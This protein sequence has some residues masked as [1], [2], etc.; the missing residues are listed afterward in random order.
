MPPND[1]PNRREAIGAIATTTLA[2][3]LPAAGSPQE[4]RTGDMVY[5]QFGKTG[6]KVSAIGLGGSHIGSPKDETMASGLSEPPLIAVSRSWTIAGI[7]TMGKAK[8]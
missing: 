5:R 6:I 3:S 4:S 8:S 1:N 7:T 2:A